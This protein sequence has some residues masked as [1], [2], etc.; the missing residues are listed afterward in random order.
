MT[1]FL[2]QNHLRKKIYTFNH[3]MSQIEKTTKNYF[4]IVEIKT[5]GPHLLIFF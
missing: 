3:L 2:N 4:S 5:S 1:K